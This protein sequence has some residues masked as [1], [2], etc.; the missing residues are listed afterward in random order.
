MPRTL[1]D[2]GLMSILAISV[3]GCGPQTPQQRLVGR[4]TGTPQV[5]DAVDAMVQSAAQGQEVN[6]LCKEQPGC[7]A[8]RWPK[9]RCP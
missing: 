8:M 5:K 6:P 4:W 3:A 2:Y 7:W 1:R 9:P